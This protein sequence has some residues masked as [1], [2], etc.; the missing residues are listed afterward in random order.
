MNSMSML[1]TRSSDLELPSCELGIL[2][3]SMNPKIIPKTPSPA[4]TNIV[5]ALFSLGRPSRLF[6]T[7]A[8]TV[9]TKYA[10]TKITMTEAKGLNPTPLPFPNM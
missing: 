4:K 7:K 8:I 1:F 6:F 5:A 9:N 2:Q 3:M 10:I